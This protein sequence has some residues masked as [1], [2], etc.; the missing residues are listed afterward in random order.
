MAGKTL[1]EAH[2]AQAAQKAAPG[3]TNKTHRN[4]NTT[5]Q[6]SMTPPQPQTRTVKTL[7]INGKQY[8]LIDNIANTALTP[9]V[10]ADTNTA[11]SA[12]SIC[13]PMYDESEYFTVLATNVN[14]S[15]SLDWDKSSTPALVYSTGGVPI[16]HANGM[17]FILNT[18]AMC[19]ISPEASDFKFKD[20]RSIPCHPVKGLG[21]SA[22]YATGIGNIELHIASGHTLKLVDTCTSLSLEFDLYL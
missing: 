17:P 1:K 8:M 10:T 18:G 20:L 11:L 2:A 5:S 22:V 19:H 13:M 12:V 4:C 16:A 14:P 3:N 9:N 15:A 6:S 7:M 21:G